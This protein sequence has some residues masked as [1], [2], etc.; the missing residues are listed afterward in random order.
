M[1]PVLATGLLNL[2]SNILQ[3]AFSPSTETPK[4]NFGDFK[5]DLAKIQAQEKPACD[6]DQLRT[7]LLDSP[8]IKEF[9]SRNPGSSIHLDQL[10]DGSVRFLSSSGDFITLR[11]EDLHCD[12]AS[13]FLHGSIA[14]G[15][16]LHPDRPNSAILTG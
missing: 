15:Q 16:N 5:S 3:K 14:S 9:I 6:L 2:G 7:N 10:S 4:A 1:E 11:P 8:E 12:I 13:R